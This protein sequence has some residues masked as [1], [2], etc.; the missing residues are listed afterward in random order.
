MAKLSN[1]LAFTPGPV[2][3]FTSIA[4]A[5][6]IIALIITHN[7]VPPAPQS[8]TPINGVNLTEAWQ[9]LQVLTP[10]YHPYN[11]RSNDQVR[12]WLLRRVNNILKDNNVTDSRDA[13]VRSRHYP[14]RTGSATKPAA[15]IFDDDVSNLTF[16][17]AGSTT[18][19]AGVSVYFEGTNIIVYIRGSQDDDTEW[20]ND[21]KGRP[22][23]KGGV[24]VNAHY[25]SV[26]TGFGATD[27]GVGVVT[28]LQLINHYTTTGNTPK[29]GLVALLNNGEEDFL[30]GARAFSQNP[31]AKFPHSFLNLEGAGAGGR[32][33][34]FRSTDV[35]VTSAYRNSPYPFGSVISGDGFA[36]GLIR[37]QTD[38]VVFN[39]ILGL[40]GLDVAFMEPRARYHTDED[41]TRHT[42]RKSL[43]HMLSSALATTQALT[44]DSTLIFEGKSTAKG[45]VEAGHGH[46]GVWFDLFGRAFALFRLHTLFSLSVTL[47]VI[48]PVFLGST[49]VIL[50]QLDKLYLF[51]GS[52]LYHVSDGD[53]RIPLYGWRGFF[54]FPLLFVIAAAA[55]VALVFL[56][57]KLNPFIAHSS[58]WSVWSMMFSSWFF[59]AWFLCCFADWA[60]PSALTRTYALT[61]L[62]TL[63]WAMLVADTVFQTHLKLAGG[64]PV[65]FYSMSLFLATWISYLELFSL[66]TKAKYCRRKM[67]S[68]RRDSISSTQLPG[69]GSQEAPA[70]PPDDQRGEDEQADE[71][72]SLLKKDKRTTFAN[73]TH[74]ETDENEV[75]VVDEDNASEKKDSYVYGDEQDWSEY[76]PRWTWLLQLILIV[77]IN[78]IL[79]GQISLLLV[80]ALHQTGSDGSSMFLVYIA[81]A[82]FSILMLSPTLPYLH[83]FTWQIPIFMLLVLVGT[84]IYNLLAFPF[85]E[86]NRLK[87]FFQQEIDLDLGNNTVSLI[88]LPWYVQEAVDSLPSSSGQ[89]LQC[90]SAVP[91]NRLKCSWIGL[92]PRVVH[93]HPQLPLAKQ[94]RTWVNYNVTRVSSKNSARFTVMGRESRACKLTFDSPIHNFMVHGSAPTDRRFPIVP[95]GGSKEIR[96]WSRTWNRAWVVDVEWEGPADQESEIVDLEGKVVCLWSDDNREGVIPALDEVRHFAPGWV[97]VTKAGDGLVE[98]YKKFKI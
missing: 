18:S 96:L 5:A 40:R 58:E 10:T 86:N 34:L 84:L 51:S 23:G 87:L 94:V 45:G 89:S 57:F 12:N 73:Y 97:A 61:W 79:L 11:S 35:E 32:A 28:I 81:M 59:T 98:G 50:Y 16:S 19:T 78:V 72:T 47:L 66:P 39:G 49:L 53:E 2:T 76:L 36:K 62:W 92:P 3:F 52:R 37:S 48:G 55:P 82:V 13:G 65:L 64:Y 68:P 88:G 71:R 6:L 80:S 46:H 60:R 33:T 22:N 85:S 8:P 4:Y 63:S 14:N 42:S 30:N 20:W 75:A 17:S 43:W 9:D 29:R 90:E 1:P 44:S 41:D 15:Y 70:A 83:R 69:S 25:D 54:R 38:Y 56:V 91:G 95:E 93:T 24:L 67:E 77:P 7:T 21:P 27:D 31:M 74:N 26:S